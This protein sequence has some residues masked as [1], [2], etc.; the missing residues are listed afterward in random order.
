MTDPNQTHTQVQRAM[1]QTACRQ[2]QS[3]LS[4][5]NKQKQTKEPTK[6]QEAKKI[7]LVL[8]TT[9][10]TTKKTSICVTDIYSTG[11]MRFASILSNI[12][13]SCYQISPREK[14][15]PKSSKYVMSVI[16]NG[17]FFVCT[18]KILPRN[19]NH[20]TFLI[21]SRRIQNDNAWFRTHKFLKH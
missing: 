12:K 6:R 13:I 10:T 17:F 5:P 8:C 4:R 14:R 19:L 9:P 3:P 18:K 1:S 20:T 16:E 11:I 15:V 21:L 7:M 2:G